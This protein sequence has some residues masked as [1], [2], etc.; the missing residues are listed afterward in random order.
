[1]TMKFQWIDLIKSLAPVG[2]SYLKFSC[3]LYLKPI[4]LYFARF[5]VLTAASMKMIA[6]WDITSCSL[7][8]VYR[9]FRGAYCLPLIAPM[10]AVVRTSETSVSFCE[11]KRRNI[12]EGC[13]LLLYSI[14]FSKKSFYSH[15][16][17]I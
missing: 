17:L 1:M 15:S 12:P 8:E 9:R 10:M 14:L 4:R 5:Q 16:S 6:F 3:L 2:R 13:H 7:I 11:S